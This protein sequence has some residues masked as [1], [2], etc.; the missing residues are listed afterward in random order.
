MESKRLLSFCHVA[1]VLCVFCFVTDS[2]LHLHEKNISIS[3]AKEKISREFIGY[4]IPT[5]VYVQYIGDFL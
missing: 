3:E 1:F 2:S 4:G 5:Q